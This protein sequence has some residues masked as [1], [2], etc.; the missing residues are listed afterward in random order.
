LFKRD[1]AA[2]G[3]G[4]EKGFLTQVGAHGGDV[5]LVFAAVHGRQRCADGLTQRVGGSENAGRPRPFLPRAG[6]AG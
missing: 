3:P 2:L 5:L 6:K 1:G 4:G